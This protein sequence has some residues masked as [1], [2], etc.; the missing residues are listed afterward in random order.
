MKKP[1]FRAN[2]L[3]FIPAQAESAEEMKK[4]A[5]RSL[6]VVKSASFGAKI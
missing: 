1:I 5:T 6:K 3:V 2:Y 4:R